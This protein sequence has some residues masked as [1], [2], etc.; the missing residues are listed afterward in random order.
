MIPF[1]TNVTQESIVAAF[2]PFRCLQDKFEPLI[3]YLK[4]VY[5]SH[6]DVCNVFTSGLSHVCHFHGCP[7][8]SDSEV[9]SD[10]LFELYHKAYLCK[11]IYVF[12]TRIVGSGRKNRGI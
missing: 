12:S 6:L 3:L 1:N 10:H 7:M 5:D 4:E 8:Q 9:K 11:S 2:M